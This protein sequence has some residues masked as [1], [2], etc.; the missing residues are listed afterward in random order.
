MGNIKTIIG[1]MNM[2]A[3]CASW[4]KYEL[5]QYVSGEKFNR[6]TS[7]ENLHLDSLYQALPDTSKPRWP[8]NGIILVSD[9]IIAVYP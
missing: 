3:F 9:E 5:L 6:T 2:S 7:K 8:T 4:S 1:D